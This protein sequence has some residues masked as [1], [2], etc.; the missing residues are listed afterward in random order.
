MLCGRWC[1]LCVGGLGLLE[2]VWRRLLLL[3]LRL[4]YCLID[5]RLELARIQWMVLPRLPRSLGLAL[6]LH[7]LQCCLSST[8]PLCVQAEVFWAAS[9][10]IMA[11]VL[12][13]S[14]VLNSN[15]QKVYGFKAALTREALSRIPERQSESEA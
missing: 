11:I 9:C 6:L 14:H 5:L 15:H 4:V 10:L 8:E 13:A 2:Q 3:V 7:H 12:S 1:C